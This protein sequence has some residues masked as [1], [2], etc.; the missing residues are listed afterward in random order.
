MADY[1]Q[2]D[3]RHSYC[4]RAIKAGTPVEL[5]ARQLGHKDAVMVLRVYGKFIPSHDERKLWED[6]AV[7]QD[8]KSGTMT[9]CAK[10]FVPSSVPRSTA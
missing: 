9:L 1:R 10:E 5:V 3:Q 7:A 4:V 2:K 6:K 8:A